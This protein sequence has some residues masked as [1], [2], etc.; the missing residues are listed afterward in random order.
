MYMWQRAVADSRGREQPAAVVHLQVSTAVW[1]VRMGGVC[2]GGVCMGG[3][4]LALAQ[5]LGL[6]PCALL[7][8]SPLTAC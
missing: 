2:M 1:E 4:P 5:R 3:R 6:A 7:I 8:C